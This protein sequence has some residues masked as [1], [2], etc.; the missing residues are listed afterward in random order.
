MQDLSDCRRFEDK[1]CG[2]DKRENENNA[3]WAEGGTLTFMELLWVHF[4]IPQFLRLDESRVFRLYSGRNGNRVEMNRTRCGKHERHR[5]VLF[6]R[7]RG[8]SR[9]HSTIPVA[10]LTFYTHNELWEHVQFHE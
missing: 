8:L 1:F 9:K 2:Y 10:F 6:S 3:E 4:S 7:T 5:V